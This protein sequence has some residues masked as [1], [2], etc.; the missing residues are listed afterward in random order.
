[1]FFYFDLKEEHILF[2]A[3]ELEQFAPIFTAH[4]FEINVEHDYDKR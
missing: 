3:N 1:M 2:A 4:N